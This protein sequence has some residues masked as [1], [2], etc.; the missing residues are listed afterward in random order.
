MACCCAVDT[1]YVCLTG[2][3]QDRRIGRPAAHQPTCRSQW[4]SSW[5]E[6]A[7]GQESSWLGSML[8]RLLA[9]AYKSRGSITIKLFVWAGI[10]I[11]SNGTICFWRVDCARECPRFYLL[12]LE[13][14]DI[15]CSPGF[16]VVIF[17]IEVLLLG[18]FLVCQTINQL[19]ITIC[20]IK[21][22]Q[23]IKH[24]IQLNHFDHWHE[25]SVNIN[26]I[27]VWF[28]PSSHSTFNGFFMQFS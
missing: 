27:G 3:A 13:R 10:S 4:S 11:K 20:S 24:S 5:P 9:S 17:L 7:F 25:L 26:S 16:Q 14:Y 19:D 15:L 2:P 6:T 1:D 21:C 22:H 18:Y 8:V 12:T 28:I 23:Q